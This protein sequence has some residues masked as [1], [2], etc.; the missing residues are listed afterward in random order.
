M[1]VRIFTLR[2]DQTIE[3]FD[4]SQFR[5]FIK[6]KEVVSLSDHFF[7]RDNVPYL[8]LVVGFHLPA[9][10]DGTKPS[11]KGVNKRDESWRELLKE[12]D[13][14]LFNTMR[15]WRNEAAKQEGIPPY[16]ICT[17][18]ELAAIVVARP[19]SL[20]GLGEIKGV[21]EGKLKKYGTAMLALLARGSAG[22]EKGA[23]NAKKPEKQD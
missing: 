3:R 2:F 8:T 21:G 7:L 20:N 9:F 19:Q 11:Q 15:G 4:D 6:D 14:P 18:R 13:I 22:K 17:N 16:V 5:D 12:N 10:E 1:D 23:D